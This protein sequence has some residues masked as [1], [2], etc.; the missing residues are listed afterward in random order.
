MK[1]P[2]SI[3]AG[4]GHQSRH[5]C[6]RDTPKSHH[7]HRSRLYGYEW[8]DCHETPVPWSDDPQVFTSYFD[9]PPGECEDHDDSGHLLLGIGGGE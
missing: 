3:M 2:K 6:N 9:K 7:H 8:S 5:E 1:C 4:P